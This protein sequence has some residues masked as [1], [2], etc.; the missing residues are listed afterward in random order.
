[1]AK[2]APAVSSSR[3]RRVLRRAARWS[4]GTLLLLLL[5]IG[6]AFGALQTG[7]GKSWL[8]ATLSDIASDASGLT[9]RIDRIEGT[10]PSDLTVGTIEIADGQGV[11]LRAAGVT[12]DWDPFDLL[13]G[14][15]SVSRVAA[16]QLEVARA[17][18]MQEAVV[19]PE[20][21][22]L[23]LQ[24]E[25]PSLPL[26]VDLADF[27]IGE[28]QLGAGL[29]GEAVSAALFGSATLD[30]R[31]QEAELALSLVRLDGVPA[32]IELMLT[33]SPPRDAAGDGVL[34]LSADITEPAGGLVA[35]L[36]DLPDLPAVELHLDGSG[37]VSGWTGRLQAAAGD[38]AADLDLALAISERIDLTVAGTLDPGGLAGPELRTLLPRPIGI[39]AALGY[40]PD[41]LLD[42]GHADLSAPG[43]TARLSGRLDQEDESVAA[44]LQMTIDDPA[45]LA[46]LGQLGLEKPVQAAAVRATARVS[47]GLAAPAIDLA[48][49][50]DRLAMP[51][52]AAADALDLSAT[53]TPDADSPA[54]AVT[55]RVAPLGF[56]LDGDPALAGLI[57]DA[58]IAA[59]DGTLDLQELR[60]DIASLEMATAALQVIG[61]GHVAEQGRDVD[62]TL[63]LRADDLAPLAGLAGQQAA[64]ALDA[65]LH[66]AGDAT[67]PRLDVDLDARG[68]N[69]TLAD[70][71][72]AAIVGAA[73][74]LVASARLDGAAVSLAHAELT[75]AAANVRTSGMIADTLDL[76]VDLSAPSLVVLSRPLGTD[77]AGAVVVSGRVTG[78]VDD[79]SVTARISG[80]RVAAAGIALG[81]PMAD[82]SAATLVS[83]PQGTLDLTAQPGGAVLRAATGFRVVDQSGIRLDDLTLEGAGGTRLAGDLAIGADGLMDGTLDGEAA[84]LSAW[85]EL[86]GTKLAGAVGLRFSANA[87]GAGQHLVVALNGRDLAAADAATASELSLEAEVG[88]ALTAPALDA[89]LSAAGVAAGGL[90]FD[91]VTATAQ[92]R[93]ADLGWAFAASG[94]GESADQAERPT[95]IA[96]EGRLALG[97]SGGSVTLATLTATI[98]AV[99]AALTRPATIAWGDE[100]ARLDGLDVTIGD[101]RLQ[102]AGSLA[103]RSMAVEAT[104]TEL[105][106]GP[107]A[108]LA[109]GGG[110][111][112]RL[113][114]A[115]SLAGDPAAP[116]GRATLSLTGLRQADV[117]PAEALPLS[118]EAAAALAAGRIDATAR[119]FGQDDIAL[120]A[121]ISAPL[122]ADGPIDGKITGNLDLA[123]VPRVVDLRGDALSGKLALDLTLSGS[124]DRPRAGGRVTIAGGAYENATQGTVLRDLAAEAVGDNA[125]IRLTSLTANDGSGGR[126]AA[127]GAVAIDAAA[128]F[129]VD[130]EIVLDKFTALRRPD[131]TVQASGKL[132]IDRRADG[133]RIAGTLTVDEAELRVPDKLSAEVV[134]LEVTEINLPPDHA[135][136][137]PPQP[138]AESPLD[139]D[140]DVRIPR[141]AFLR[142]RGLDSEW[143]GRLRVGGTTATPDIVGSLDVV[144]GS[145]DLLGRNFRFDEGEV[146]FVGGDEIDPELRF[147]AQSEAEALNVKAEVSGTASAPSFALSSDPPLPQDEILARLLFGSS[148]GSLT[149]IQAVQL[150]QTAATLSGQ[151]GPVSVLDKLRQGF[152]LDM[153]GVESGETVSSSSLTVGKYLTDDVF[154]KMNQGVTPES[155]KIG[156][157]VRVMP[158]V[159]VE[160]DIGA[161]SQGSVGVNWKLDY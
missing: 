146:R 82:I 23:S 72:L 157:E 42:I 143:Q 24:L 152:G 103:D 125:Q 7:A 151:G 46:R 95:D 71:L 34:T 135:P 8:A 134:T 49:T 6:L 70:P 27:E 73:P 96:A 89:R 117:D 123:L 158:R 9:V 5:L 122:A 130:A 56:A 85:Q 127:S 141:R 26:D 75:A 60:L 136:H 112:G 67:V 22:P 139:L 76:T 114:G 4:V 39:D 119:L 156:V 48:A 147:I 87:E 43:V 21:Q 161:E 2:P 61:A 38:A 133:G 92:G 111:D 20:P 35:R 121:A 116:Q 51:G 66:L 45:L 100:G 63:A 17:P 145:L 84:D 81:D 29:L 154:V 19:A 11:W 62:L 47:G 50:V 148:A 15:L 129:P 98:A 53:L 32:R 77:L 14:R 155:R 120:D 68:G 13:A 18:A 12:L 106:V 140:I 118:G 94:D 37:P 10:V 150:A 80:S 159:T 58:P 138:T 153:L 33:Q 107:L 97:D 90:T 59:L 126:L 131:A 65:E 144:R 40:V 1:M 99:E 132:D 110:L 124:R 36:L 113:S 160:S 55:A 137:T 57:G 25:L 149:P 28:M 115:V 52:V 86:A 74:R 3:P 104:L 128:G 142:G 102:V 101:G 108:E 88:D 41:R 93:L 54:L 69:V 91:S 109:G 79:P 30:A 105:P 31:P 44:A 16:A 64:G 83:A 78:A